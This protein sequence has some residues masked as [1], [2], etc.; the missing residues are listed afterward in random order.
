MQLRLL[1]HDILST[2]TPSKSSHKKNKRKAARPH[3]VTDQLCEPE[4]MTEVPCSMILPNDTGYRCNWFVCVR[5]EGRRC[6]VISSRGKT[7]SYLENGR[8][9]HQFKSFLP[10][11]GLSSQ[12]GSS[13]ILDCIYYEPTKIYYILDIMSWNDMHCYECDAEFRFYWLRAKV[14]ETP[15]ITPEFTSSKQP[16]TFLPIPYWECSWMGLQEA[17]TCS[18]PFSKNGLLFYH[19]EGQ[20]EIGLTPLVLLWKDSSVTNYLDNDGDETLALRVGN[21]GAVADALDM[22]DTNDQCESE[23]QISAVSQGLSSS[24]LCADP[25]LCTLENIPLVPLSSIS[26]TDLSPEVASKWASL[27]NG[28]VIRGAIQGAGCDPMTGDPFVANFVVHKVIVVTL[29]ISASLLTYCEC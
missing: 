24:E 25:W 14:D 20:Y 29:Y 12:N 18:L 16:H 6:V 2:A 22:D 7:F 8:V 21:R 15:F 5:P 28:S 13:A 10:G 27:R 11:G 19:R 23:G 9:L 3:I 1:S 4:W 17:Y 26:P